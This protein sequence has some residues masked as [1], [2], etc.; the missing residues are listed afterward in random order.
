MIRLASK[1]DLSTINN[2]VKEMFFEVSGDP[3][4]LGYQDNY[5]E[6]FVANKGDVIFVAEENK[7]IV[8]FISVEQHFESENFIYFDDFCVTKNYRNRSIGKSLIFEALN[9]ALIN[10]FD[11]IFLHV[12]KSNKKAISLYEKLCFEISEETEKRFKFCLKLPQKVQYFVNNQNYVC[13]KLLGKGKGGYT[14]KAI[15]NL[16][17]FV[18]LKLI[19]H[20]PCDYY[21]F[22]DKFEAEINDYKTLT[23]IGILMPKLIGADKEKEVIV[24]E[25]ID[26]PTIAQMIES[27]ND[28]SNYV[29]EMKEIAEKLKR[30][31]LNIDYFPTNFMVKEN[32]LIYVDFE[33]NKFMDEWSFE[34]WGIK[35][36]SKW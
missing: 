8:G 36:W 33:C 6:K 3:N 22:G 20:E 4:Q 10:N 24:K 15:N 17:E 29:P 30:N 32:K 14:Y 23:E 21:N 2:L 18:A 26:G 19:H 35:Y 5:L 13:L 9:Y 7:N 16:G 11:T 31:N 27:G 28:V 1:N 12:E 34:N 25:L